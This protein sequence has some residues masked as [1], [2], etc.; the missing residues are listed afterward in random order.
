MKLKLTLLGGVA[1]MLANAAFAQ[2]VIHKRNGDVVEGRVKEVGRNTVTYKTNDEVASPS[3]EINKSEVKKIEYEDGTIEKFESDSY[4]DRMRVSMDSREKGRRENRRNRKDLKYG[5]NILAFAP[6]QISENGVGI[7]LS[8]E[9][10]LDKKGIVS[11][12]MP[13][14]WTFTGNNGDDYGY[15]NYNGGYNDDLQTVYFMPGLKIYPTGSKG[16]VKYSIGPSLLFAVGEAYHQYNSYSTPYY[17]G[18][19]YYYPQY[20]PYT[21]KTNRFT[22]GMMVNNTLN[23]NPTEHLHLGLEL[24]LGVSYLHTE[25]GIRQEQIGLAQFGFKVGYRF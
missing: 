4:R 8:Y 17:G 19:P 23:V 7:G 13:V 11:F 18:G 15:Y 2:D 1:L 12:Y 6:L 21:G 20:Y 3:Y 22:F 14:V 25:D 16:L 24:G 10:S 5:D 9:R